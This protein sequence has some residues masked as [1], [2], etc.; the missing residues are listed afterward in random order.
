[1]QVPDVLAGTGLGVLRVVQ[2]D[3]PDAELL[4]TT[5]PQPVPAP[6]PQGSGTLFTIRGPLTTLGR[7]ARNDVV[8]TDPTVS[9]EHALLRVDGGLWW[10][11]NVSAR[12][13]LWVGAVEAAPGMSLPVP[14]G[15]LL[16]LGQTTLQLLAPAPETRR[17]FTEPAGAEGTPAGAAPL[18]DLGVTMQFA[19]S[20][21]LTPRAR[22]LVVA[23]GALAF[24]AGAV[25]LASTLALVRQATLNTQGAGSALAALAIPLVPALGAAL[26]VGFIDRYEREPIVLLVAAFAWG[27]VIAS[28]A[29]LVVERTLARGLAAAPLVA[30]G[31]H[32]ALA[33]AAQAALQGLSAG[34]AE[35][36]V[37][38]AGLV[39]LLLLLRDEFDNVTDGILYGVLIGAGFALVENFVYFAASPRAQLGALV[40]GRVVLGWLGHSTFTALF[41]AGLGYARETRD[42][43]TQWLAP[44]L[45]FVAAV[46]LHSLFDAVDFFASA[47]A[48]TPGV[49]HTIATVALAAVL[50]NYLPLFAAQAILWRML[51]RALRREEDIVREYLAPEVSA[52]IVTPDEYV[53]LQ[54]YQERGR[55]EHR[56][57]LLW[58]PRAYLTARDLHQTATGL[59]FRKWHVALGDR[60]KPTPRQPEDAYRERIPRLR[61]RLLRL[62]APAV[63]VG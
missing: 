9:R 60:P 8:L 52:G 44:L 49:G 12:N 59:A 34:V 17:L 14:G 38:G 51:L 63:P 32:G 2:V 30:A 48:H 1:M 41:G 55:F 46:A 15:S 6:E 36:C 42:R 10:V 29:A 21:R 24:L 3:E 26:L 7:G 43:R 4:A 19:L 20:R 57:L 47:V 25:A 37:K 28:P 61:Q 62:A 53:L 33:L 13:P 56:C 18:L 31:A 58:G 50:I 16:R 27:V 11:E 45:G 22:V 23:L 5:T 39:V 54:R 35:E 40:L